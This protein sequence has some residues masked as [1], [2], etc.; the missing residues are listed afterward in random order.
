M[1]DNLQQF[2]K[3]VGK[4]KLLTREEEVELSKRIEKGDDRARQRMINANCR[5]SYVIVSCRRLALLGHLRYY[6]FCAAR[7]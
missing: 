4:T 2:F 5:D 6:I 7:A 3:Q 1:A